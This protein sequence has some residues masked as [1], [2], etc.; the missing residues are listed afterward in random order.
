MTYNK[1]ITRRMMEVRSSMLKKKKKDGRES[2]N[3]PGDD[4][5]T[6]SGQTQDAKGNLQISSGVGTAQKETVTPADDQCKTNSKGE[7]I[8]TRESC[9]KLKNMT[10]EEIEESE[11]KQ[12]LRTTQ[13]GE[14]NISSDP[15]LSKEKGGSSIDLMTSPEGRAGSR[16]NKSQRRITSQMKRKLA[17]AK[18]N[19]QSFINKRTKDGVFTPPKPGEPGYRKYTRY[20]DKEADFSQAVKNQIAQFDN[21]TQQTT[22]MR[23]PYVTKRM[24]YGRDLQAGTTG[25]QPVKAPEDTQTVDDFKQPFLEFAGKDG[26]SAQPPGNS[27]QVTSF[28]SLLSNDAFQPVKIQGSGLF[29]NLG[30]LGEMQEKLQEAAKGSGVKMLKKQGAF[31]M[32]KSGFKK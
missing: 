24:E 17:K 26:G 25:G 4:T 18:D 21:V 9:Q 14:V 10:Q 2:Y 28:S 3:G 1:P 11:R 23:N 32:R 12:G 20:K 30:S 8:D 31:K 16:L 29:E 22:G 5:M 15:V 13:E 6:G 7:I 27:G 19:L